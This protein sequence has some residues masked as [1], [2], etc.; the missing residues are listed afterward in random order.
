MKLVACKPGAAYQIGRR[1][2]LVD[3]A[4][5]GSLEHRLLSSA[6]LALRGLLISEIDTQQTI[7]QVEGL[8]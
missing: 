1:H 2:A 5:Q 4:Q 3:S 6:Q 7:D 8:I